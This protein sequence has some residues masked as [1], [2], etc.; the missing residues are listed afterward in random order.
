MV[1]I[2]DEL[3]SNID[4]ISESAV[5]EALYDNTEL[6][7]EMLN[8]NRE[9]MLS[10]KDALNGGDFKAGTV[11]GAFT[12]KKHTAVMVPVFAFGPGAEYFMGIQENTDLY[13]HMMH[14]MELKVSRAP[15]SWRA[16]KRN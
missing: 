3:A 11:K 1:T 5:M 6:L 8:A 13:T 4:R 9:Q 12:T 2:F 10:G 7:D 15:V 16:I 14:L